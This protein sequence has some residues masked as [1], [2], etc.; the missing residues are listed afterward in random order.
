MSFLEPLCLVYLIKKRKFEWLLTNEEVQEDVNC[1]IN[2][3]YFSSCMPVAADTRDCIR[4]VFQVGPCYYCRKKL[5]QMVNKLRTPLMVAATYDNIDS[6]RLIFLLLGCEHPSKV[7]HE[8]I[9]QAILGMDVICQAK[10]G[11]GKTIVFVLSTLQQIDPVP[12]PIS[13]LVFC[14]QEN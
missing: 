3:G 11:M 9:P 2:S 5:T 12:D 7:Q 4:L 13:M 6:V 14:I 10:S 8:C 1:I